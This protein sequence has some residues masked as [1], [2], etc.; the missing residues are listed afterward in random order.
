MV[1]SNQLV[2]TLF[3]QNRTQEE[4]ESLDDGEIDELIEDAKASAQESNPGAGESVLA[5]EALRLMERK[6]TGH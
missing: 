4:I 5:S 1:K 6:W 2:R 3:L